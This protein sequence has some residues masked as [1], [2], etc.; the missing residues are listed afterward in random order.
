M[1]GLGTQQEHSTGRRRVRRAQRWRPEGRGP[2]VFGQL[3][4]MWVAFSGPLAGCLT[5]LRYG[6]ALGVL[7]PR[8]HRFTALLRRVARERVPHAS[9][10]RGKSGLLGSC[11]RSNSR[12]RGHIG[13]LDAWISHVIRWPHNASLLP[14]GNGLALVSITW[15]ILS[16]LVVST[17]PVRVSVVT[18]SGS[19]SLGCHASVQHISNRPRTTGAP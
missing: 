13:I 8:A 2:I 14:S 1:S 10:P 11:S 17:S 9:G 15:A 19:I 18:T 6:W 7:P 16:G 5:R 4:A 3:A 12:H